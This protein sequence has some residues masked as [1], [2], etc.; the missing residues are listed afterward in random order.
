[1]T[2]TV[3]MTVDLPGFIRAGR[4][5]CAGRA[6]D[7]SCFCFKC[8]GFAYRCAACN[9]RASKEL[10]DVPLSRAPELNPSRWALSANPR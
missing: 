5:C 4:S 8:F 7:R 1:M 9:P 10:A 6:R 2:K 3:G